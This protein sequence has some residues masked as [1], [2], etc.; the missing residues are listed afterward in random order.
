MVRL[1]NARMGWIFKHPYAT[2][3]ACAGLIL[4]TITLV[5]ENRITLRQGAVS[6][7]GANGAPLLNP[8]SYA[9]RDR[10]SASSPDGVT[11][12]GTAPIYIPPNQTVGAGGAEQS[13]EFD[14]DSFLAALSRPE[15]AAAQSEVQTDMSAAYSFIPRGLIATSSPVREREPVEQA[16]FDYGNEAGSHIQTYEDSHRNAATVLR[17]QAE[18]RKN[19]SKAQAVKTVAAAIRTV[20]ENLAAIEQVPAG[21][22]SLHETLA[23]NYRE[24]GEA[25]AL[26]PD[27]SGDAAFITAI[28]NYNT[29]ADALV[30]TFVA[31]ATLFSVQG[32]TFSTQDPGSVFMFSGG[33]GL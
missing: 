7:W 22:K 31:L 30:K 17:D 15:Q 9:P 33:S 27:A 11:P 32:V 23:R 14:F 29:S 21:A 28:E 19:A 18:D 2:L 12:D 24:V 4:I 1:Y 13:S 8:A 16:L 20:G 5:V 6:A 3:S 10:S 25:L 26:V